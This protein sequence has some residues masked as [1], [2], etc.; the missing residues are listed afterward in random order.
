MTL[1][2][3]KP[4]L[5]MDDKPVTGPESQSI[6]L[7]KFL[8]SV[9]SQDIGGSNK[10]AFKID[11]A[12]RIAKE[13][14]KGQVI[15]VTDSEAELLNDAILNSSAIT[16]LKHQLLAVIKETKLSAKPEEAKR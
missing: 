14:H 11:S 5:D 2:F 8:S 3:H 6:F 12:M 13:L 4:F 1:N 7:D 10:D 15:S 16:S 9:L